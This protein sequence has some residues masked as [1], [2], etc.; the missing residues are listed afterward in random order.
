MIKKILIIIF[1]IILSVTSYADE[2]EELFEEF[3]IWLAKNEFTEYYKVGF[4]EPTGKCKELEKF[5]QHWYYNNC[6]EDKK[7]VAI[8]GI[9]LYPKKLKQCLK[10]RDET[11]EELKEILNYTSENEYEMTYGE[12]NDSIGY[13]I[14]L[15]IQGGSIRTWCTD[16][17][18]KTEEEKNWDDDFNVSIETK[19]FLYWTI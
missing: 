19:E 14:D 9:K 8:S 11:V 1:S 17:D 18:N 6:D 10:K 5:S 16:W 4:A 12:G 13:V 7:I 3:N 2:Q 15:K